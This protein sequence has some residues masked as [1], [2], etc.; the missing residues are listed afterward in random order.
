MNAIATVGR[1]ALALAADC[2]TG[3]DVQGRPS[4]YAESCACSGGDPQGSPAAA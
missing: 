2:G 4:A 1:F 3:S